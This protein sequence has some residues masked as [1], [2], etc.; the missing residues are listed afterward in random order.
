MTHCS[1]NIAFYFIG[2]GSV[3]KDSNQDNIGYSVMGIQ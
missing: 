1:F 3:R 2:T